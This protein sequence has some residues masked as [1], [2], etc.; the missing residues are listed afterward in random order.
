MLVYKHM[1]VDN[2]P[3]VNQC[4]SAGNGKISLSNADWPHNFV[5]LDNN[6]AKSSYDSFSTLQF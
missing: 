6:E 2:V 5:L 4:A 1:Q 3:E